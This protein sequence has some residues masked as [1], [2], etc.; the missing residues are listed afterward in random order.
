MHFNNEYFDELSRSAG[1]TDLCVKAAEK[2]ADAARASAPV[3]SG[4]YRDGIVV[5]TKQQQRSVAV[6]KGTDPKTML[7]ESKTGNLARALRTVAR[8]K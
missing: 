1:V 2:V 4:D 5:V 3:D 7:I 6:V 8:Q